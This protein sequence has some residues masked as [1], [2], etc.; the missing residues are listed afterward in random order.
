MPRPRKANV[1]RDRA[2]KSRGESAE[3]VQAVVLAQ[4]IRAGA[5]PKD[6]H[7][8]LWG[9]TLGILRCLSQVTEDQYDAG[10]EYAEIVHRHNALMGIG[11]PFP[12]SPSTIMVSGGNGGE[13]RE[14]SESA[15]IDIRRK[16]SDCRRV[17]LD[18]RVTTGGGWQVNK[19]TYEVC[20]ENRS[21]DTLTPID[22]KNL[23]IGLKA[24]GK[25]LR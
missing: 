23:G 19:I 25:V 20:V 8:H 15:V 14:P 24:L 21:A 5:P 13:S 6:A 11:M 16:F 22:H 1:A 18:P 17:L 2:G 9:F 10:Y 7:S 3:A 4:R 12:K